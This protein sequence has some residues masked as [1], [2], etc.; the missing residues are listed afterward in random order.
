[1]SSNT[2]LSNN[3]R[4]LR[5][6]RNLSQE[7]LAARLGIKRSNIAAY[8]SKNVEPRLRI[9][10]E[11]A[12]LF[13]IQLK[14]FIEKKLDQEDQ[15]KRF[16]DEEEI[17][18]N[19]ARLPVTREIPPKKVVNSFKESSLKIRKILEGFKAFYQFR[20]ERI[21]QKTPEIS[22]LMFDIENFIQLTEHLL[23]QNEFVINSISPGDQKTGHEHES[24][25]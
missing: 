21:K 2:P 25:E 22:K 13:D 10:L 24:A 3:I 9:I 4:V 18:K 12:K 19:T 8:E 17:R 1:M 14:T 20:K 7:Q 23:T 5:K 16:K 15:Y 11:M 6:K